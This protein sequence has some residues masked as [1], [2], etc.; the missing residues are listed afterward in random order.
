MERGFLTSFT[1]DD[2]PIDPALDVCDVCGG[3]MAL[4]NLEI[5]WSLVRRTRW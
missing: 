3:V 4:E 5:L 2:D 1:C